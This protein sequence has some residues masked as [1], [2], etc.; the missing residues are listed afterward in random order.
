MTMRI[1]Q[2]LQIWLELGWIRAVDLQFAQHLTELAPLRDQ[3]QRDELLL[4]LCLLSHQVGRGHVCIELDALFNSPSTTL[5]LPPQEKRYSVQQREMLRR[6]EH[7]T[8]EKL[9]T[10]LSA[11]TISAALL[12]AGLA[13]EGDEVAPLVLQQ[14]RL[15]MRRYWLYETQIAAA[16]RQR[17]ELRAGLDNRESTASQR[18]K[19]S[20]ERLF[21]STDQVDYQRA[22]CALA[23]RTRFSLITGGPGTGKTTTVI[24][25]LALLQSIAALDPDSGGRK[26]KIELAAP[27]GKAAA[28]LNESIRS[29]I[30][31]LPF[32]AFEGELEP[33]DLP[34]KVRTLHRLLGS[35][36]YS[37]EFRHN[38]DNPLP[39][40][41]LVIDEASM[42]DV[43]MLAAVVAAL[44]DHAQLVLIGDQD[45]LAS[46]E[47]G[48]VLGELCARSRA[49]FYQ[50]STL[51][52]LNGVAGVQIPTELGNQYGTA[53]DQSVAMLRQSY[54]FDAGSGIGKLA[55]AINAGTQL[56][57]TISDCTKGHYPDISFLTP[58]VSANQSRAEALLNRV[59]S[60]ACAGYSLYLNQLK[61]ADLNPTARDK[62]AQALLETYSRYQLLTPVRQGEFGVTELNQ[63]IALQLHK[64]ELIDCQQE[65]YPG[66]PIMVSANDYNLGLM[67]GDIGI[68]LQIDGRVLVAFMPDDTEGKIRWI[69]PSRL[70]A[71]ETVFAMTV[72]KSQGS[73]FEHCA[74]V[75]PPKDSPVLTRELVYTAVTRAR[76][77]FT[78][79]IDQPQ[80][81]LQVAQRRTERASG[82][83]SALFGQGS[84]SATESNKKFEQPSTGTADDKNEQLG[85]F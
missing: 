32:G 55:L 17:L 5:A 72:H 41:V 28:R 39:L 45:Q 21:Q 35:R 18:V 31:K 61:S 51:E 20:L 50:A 26:Y 47:A 52:W 24:K 54:R 56:T 3:Q 2:A 27:T 57:E 22:A 83:G 42:V 14:N 78:L 67:N 29:A 63:L 34:T 77:R 76:S 37:R 10:T 23:A 16:I 82:L 62:S 43:S 74:L 69:P 80:S 9:L 71:H 59:A 84:V 30:A 44:P 53:M 40:D 4:I 64:Q 6:A 33:A 46:V 15:Y 19:L 36:R 60:E 58:R 11:S 75:M 38:R 25:L 79:V 81:L 68:C 85:L 70:P 73:E 66:R 49:G 8:P 65:W 13:S 12:T 7:S 48:S 1:A